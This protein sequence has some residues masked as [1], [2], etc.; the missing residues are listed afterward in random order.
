MKIKI[1]KKIIIPIV[2]ILVFGLAFHFLKSDKVK[3]VTKEVTEETIIQSVEASGTIK[4]INTIEVGTQV[5]GTVAKIYVD[6]NSIVKEGDLLAELDPSLFQAN[7]DQ[8]TAKLN[9][10]QATYSKAVST[11]NYKKSNY[12]RYKHLYEKNYVSKD[13]V[14]LALSNYQQAQ[15]EVAAASAEVSAAQA[16]LNNNLTNL[17]YSKITSPV[18]GTVISRAVDVGQ[19]VAASFSTPTLFEVAKDLT[20]MQIETSVSEADIGKVKV[21]QRAEY[22]LDGYQDRTFEGKVTQVRLASTTTNNVVTYT[23]I[24]SVD[25]SEGLVIP[26][27]TANV[28]IITNEVKDALCVPLQALKFTPDTNTKK[29]DEQGVWISTRNGLVRYNVK[30]GISDDSKTQIIS[31]EIKAGDKVVIS[32]SGAKNGSKSSNAGG[33]PPM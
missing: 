13:E 17:G 3:Y 5:S 21:G 14:E 25:N 22:T 19:T 1:S 28:S 12:Q 31:D 16:T 26:G 20:Q 18:D 9:N 8:S 15:A 7:V 10:A 24:I 32:S 30:I 33:P 6:Y 29:Y 4:P 27:M 2:I 11:L 23:V